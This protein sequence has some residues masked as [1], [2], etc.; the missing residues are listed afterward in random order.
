[1]SKNGENIEEIV[2]IE[3]SYNFSRRYVKTHSKATVAMW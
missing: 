3:F 2:S 1:M